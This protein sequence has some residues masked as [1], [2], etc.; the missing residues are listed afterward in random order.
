MGTYA[1]EQ[2]TLDNTNYAITYNGA[3]LTIGQLAVT[4]DADAQSKTY[5]D[6]DPA[7]TFVSVPQ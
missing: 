4:V 6:V 2:N 1:I 5:G 3:L 7:L